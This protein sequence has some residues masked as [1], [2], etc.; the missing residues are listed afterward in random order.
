MS[1]DAPPCVG[2]ATAAEV[3][4]AEAFAACSLLGVDTLHPLGFTDA[5]A[6]DAVGG[7]SGAAPHTASLDDVTRRL[8][9]L[10]PVGPLDAVAC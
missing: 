4:G 7:D 10:L 8:A 5:G 1:P 9:D 2:F 3:R 6:D